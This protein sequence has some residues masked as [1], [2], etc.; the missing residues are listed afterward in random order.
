L[1][2]RRDD[3][4]VP[5]PGHHPGWSNRAS[6]DWRLETEIAP[7][8]SLTVAD[9]ASGFVN[10]GRDAGADDLSNDLKEA[11]LTWRAGDRLFLDAGRVNLRNGVAVGFNPTDYFKTNAVA[12]RVSEDPSV[13]RENRLGTVMGRALAVWEGGS[14]T[15][16]AA[17]D[18]RDG[19]VT[20][21]RSGSDL[22]LDRTNGRARLLGKVSVVVADDFQPEFLVH[23]RSGDSPAFGLTLTRAIGDR[24]VIYAEWSGQRRIGLA[25]RDQ[26]ERL[27]SQVAAGFSYTTDFKLTANVELHVNEAGFTRG[28][29]R[30]WFAAGAA[31]ARPPWR[32]RRSAREEQEPL[33]RYTLF[34]RAHWQDALAP[35]IDLTALGQTNL[36][37]GSAF[38]QLEAAWRVADDR[39][40]SLT[41]G[42]FLGG[43]GTEYGSQ[44]DAATVVGKFTRFF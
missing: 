15:L 13:L 1:N 28:Q 10:D 32:I 22:G 38:A 17:P 37:D 40:L 3:V 12:T 34:V 24:V 8:W 2:H 35:D 18:L 30:Q 21:E 23:H 26:Q 44:P 36:Y 29:W 11:Y 31:D 39:L 6:V 19:T 16:A 9:R 42:G 27:R 25:A 20:G 4:P 33:N 5:R 43:S 7:A 41:A 14:A